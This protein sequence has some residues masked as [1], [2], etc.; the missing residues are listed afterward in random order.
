MKL[1]T[2]D[3]LV[4]DRGW[5]PSPSRME[6]LAAPVV[7]LG[8][9]DWYAELVWVEDAEMRLLNERYRGQ[10]K[11]TDVLSFSNLVVAGAG[12]PA[13]SG[14]K[15]GACADL[16]WDTGE[17][18]EARAAGEIVIAPRFVERTCQEAGNDFSEELSLLVVHGVLHVLGWDHV[19]EAE[20][21]AMHKVESNVLAA[22]GL[23][24]PIH[25]KGDG[26]DGG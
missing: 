25:V 20:T 5:R 22:C 12:K 15:S 2:I 17:E 6:I 23:P 3:R 13:L 9:A 7:S 18:P 11:V 24:H 19:T 26:P 1:L 10:D 8:R 16:W 21:E 14:G 4:D